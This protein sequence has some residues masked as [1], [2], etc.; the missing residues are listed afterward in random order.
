MMMDQPV[1]DPD[2]AGPA[3]ALLR[4]Q[5]IVK[6]FGRMVAVDAVDFDVRAGEIHALL[7]ENGAGKSTLMNCLFGLA[8]PDV[9]AQLRAILT[10]LL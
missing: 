7:G 1:S 8:R 10:E 4:M 6:R 5:G 9:A 2:Q 3:V